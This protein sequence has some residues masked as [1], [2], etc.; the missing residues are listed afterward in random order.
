[1]EH[2]YYYLHIAPIEKHQQK[3]FVFRVTVL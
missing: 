2:L 1:V 3:M